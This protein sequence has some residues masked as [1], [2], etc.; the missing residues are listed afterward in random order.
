MLSPAAQRRILYAVSPSVGNVVAEWDAF[1]AGT[2]KVQRAFDRI[3]QHLRELD[4]DFASQAR[5]LSA[6]RATCGQ[7]SMSI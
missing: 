3:T 4:V 1:V 6:F 5:L 2:S 7:R